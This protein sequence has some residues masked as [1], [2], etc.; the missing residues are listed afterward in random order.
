MSPKEGCRPA[1]ESML[2]HDGRIV[3]ARR[4]GFELQ[5]RVND[6]ELTRKALS[7]IELY[8]LD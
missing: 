1:V 7:Q 6:A 4:G 2:W 8:G 5:R 3:F